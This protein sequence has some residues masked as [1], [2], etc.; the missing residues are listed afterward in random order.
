MRAKVPGLDGDKTGEFAGT[1][2]AG[3][4]KD[5]KVIY[6]KEELNNG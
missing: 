6:F 4:G 3:E 2:E 5:A 1:R